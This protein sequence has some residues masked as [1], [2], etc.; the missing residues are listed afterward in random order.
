MFSDKPH[1]ICQ[2]DKQTDPSASHSFHQI[3]LP[4]YHPCAFG[5]LIMKVKNLSVFLFASA[6]SKKERASGLLQEFT[7][8]CDGFDPASA[9]RSEDFLEKKKKKQRL[10]LMGEKIVGGTQVPTGNFLKH[11]ILFYDFGFF[12]KIKKIIRGHG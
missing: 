8:S 2:G 5:C 1:L 7:Q 12:I 11:K 10:N 9:S 4:S 6:S 3:D